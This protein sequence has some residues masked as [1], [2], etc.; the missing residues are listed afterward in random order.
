MDP[1]TY[2][3]K[4]MTRLA[5]KTPVRLQAAGFHLHETESSWTS[6]DFI[7]GTSTIDWPLPERLPPESVLLNYLGNACGHP[8][9][10]GS[11]F[12]SQCYLE[13]GVCAAIC[14]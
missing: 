3:A 10:V 7:L 14:I 8:H 13:E 4:G 1:V 11:V 12:W 9:S 6:F 2:L 5:S